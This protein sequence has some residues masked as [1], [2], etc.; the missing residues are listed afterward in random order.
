MDAVMLEL[1]TNGVYTKDCG[2]PLAPGQWVMLFDDVYK[3]PWRYEEV[4]GEILVCRSWHIK[5]PVGNYLL[6]EFLPRNGRETRGW[7]W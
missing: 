6:R 1:G 5:A 3:L 2:D 7:P 4:A